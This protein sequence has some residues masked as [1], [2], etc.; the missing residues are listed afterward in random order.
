MK[1]KISIIVILLSVG[2]S[3]SQEIAKDPLFIKYEESF[4]SIHNNK[5]VD[6]YNLKFDEYVDKINND[7]KFI[8][9]V[10]EL[11]KHLKVDLSK[12]K[13][14]TVEEGVFL[15]EELKRYHEEVDNISKEN[16]DLFKEL[17]KKYTAKEIFEA[18]EKRNDPFK[19]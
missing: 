3:F 12:T 14:K 17:Q 1:T 5:I 13:F 11:E 16:N 8:C 9:T 15:N 18:Y 7:D 6:L 4:K 2:N 19:I 10:D